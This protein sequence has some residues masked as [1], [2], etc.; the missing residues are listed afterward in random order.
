MQLEF[1]NVEQEVERSAVVG[2]AKVGA[3]EGAV[4]ED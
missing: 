1:R 2:E 4:N 3:G